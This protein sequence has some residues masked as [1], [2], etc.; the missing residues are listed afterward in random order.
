MKW[1]QHVQS[2]LSVWRKRLL[3]ATLDMQE[4]VRHSN[5]QLAFLQ[6]ISLKGDTSHY[7]RVFQEN[8]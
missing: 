4:N 3:S 6:T 7:L 8:P 5:L 1:K 2:F